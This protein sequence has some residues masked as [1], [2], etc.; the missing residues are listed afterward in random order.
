MMCA[1]ARGDQRLGRHTA[2]VQAIAAHLVLF[3]Q[4]DFLADAGCRSERQS[5]R[6]RADDAEINRNRLAAFAVSPCLV[7]RLSSNLGHCGLPNV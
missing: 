5:A 6:A 4:H 3:N 1:L 7:R 2:V